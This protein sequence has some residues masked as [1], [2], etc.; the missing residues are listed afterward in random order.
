MQKCCHSGLRQRS[1]M[2][3]EASDQ[4]DALPE[5]C[6]AATG[7][8][9]RWRDLEE[10]VASEGV[11]EMCLAR[12]LCSLESWVV[13][14]EIAAGLDIRRPAVGRVGEVGD[15]VCAHAPGEREPLL[16]GLRL[17]RCGWL[18]AVGEQL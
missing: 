5:S 10:L 6:L 12:V 15:P 17:L 4:A 3:P 18:A 11:G 2:S 7:V 1:G 9:G 13:G 16:L 14:V 8:E